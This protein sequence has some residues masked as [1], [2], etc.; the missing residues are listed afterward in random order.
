MAETIKISASSRTKTGTAECRRLRREGRVPANIYGHRQDPVAISLNEDDIRTLLTGGTK[1]LDLDVDGTIDK[2]LV[3]EVQWD[4]YSTHVQHLDFMR[5]D[6]DERVEVE[7]PIHLRGNAPGV[8][9]GGILEQQVHEIAV[10]CMAVNVPDDIVIR[11]GSLEIGDTITAGDIKD[12]PEGVKLA[13]PDDTMILHIVEPSAEPVE[14]QEVGAEA[15]EPEVIGQK[16]DEG[17]EE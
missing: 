5:V 17:G 13:V 3:K 11:I 10:E 4:T 15:G 9:A 12:V 14:E 16:E 2:A 1:V 6:P 8:I 7:V